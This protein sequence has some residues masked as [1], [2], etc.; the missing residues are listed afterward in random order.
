VP[1]RSARLPHAW[2]AAVDHD[3]GPVRVRLAARG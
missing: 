2:A 1:G 3:G